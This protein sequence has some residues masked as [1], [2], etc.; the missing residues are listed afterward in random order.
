MKLLR[1]D[2]L[3]MCFGVRDAIQLAR[4]EALQQPI[5]VLGDLV[6]NPTVIEDLRSLGARFERSLD[7][8]TPK[9]SSSPPTAPASGAGLR[10]GP[11]DTAWS[12]PPARWSMSP[13]P[14]SHAWSTRDFIR[15]S[16]ASGTTPR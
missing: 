4:T 10:S 6:H 11:G 12:R 14:H 16:S 15:W 9:R 8:V 1:A 3:G 5:T 13:T 2:H 7:A